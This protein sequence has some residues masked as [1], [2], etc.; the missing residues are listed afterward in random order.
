MV[1]PVSCTVSSGAAAVVDHHGR[2]LSV[3]NLLFAVEV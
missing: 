3:D 2:D 1:E